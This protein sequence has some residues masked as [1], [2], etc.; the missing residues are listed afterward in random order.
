MYMKE[1][2]KNKIPAI[3]SDYIE[4]LSDPK[5][6]KWQKDMYCLTLERIQQ[7]CQDAI[8]T[9]KITAV[10]SSKIHYERKENR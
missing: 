6:N 9:Y 8:N 3:V 2:T 1:E 10:K 4:K 7:A 5:S